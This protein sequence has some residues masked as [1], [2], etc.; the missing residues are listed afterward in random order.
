MDSYST[1]KPVNDTRS[2]TGGGG[3]AMAY[4]NPPIETGTIVRNGLSANE[5]TLS[6]VHEAINRLESRLETALTPM[7][8]QPA[9]TSTA[10]P[11]GPP[12]S[13]VAYRLAQLN[14]GY[15]HAANRLRE[16]LQRVEV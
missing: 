12:C 14:D 13:Q 15:R 8:P 9:G 11:T 6:E 1:S 2:Y 3:G 7:P 4:D 16:L 10:A 5:E